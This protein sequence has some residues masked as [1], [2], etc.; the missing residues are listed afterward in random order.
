MLFVKTLIAQ[1]GI[2]ATLKILESS[3]LRHDP[4]HFNLL[5]DIASSWRSLQAQVL[6]NTLPYHQIEITSSAL[7]QR[8]LSLLDKI[9]NNYRH[10]TIAIAYSAE[11]EEDAMKI[12]KKLQPVSY[13]IQLAFFPEIS[14]GANAEVPVV[15]AVLSIVHLANQAWVFPAQTIQIA[16][17][18]QL[19][20]LLLLTNGNTPD[21]LP[22][23]W[24]GLEKQ[25]LNSI[26][27]EEKIAIWIGEKLMRAKA[28][29]SPAVQTHVLHAFPKGPMVSF[30]MVSRNLKDAY[31]AY[32]QPAQA[33]AVLSEAIAFRKQADPEESQ[34]TCIRHAD[35]PAP[36]AVPPSVYWQAAFTEAC[37]HGPRMLAAMLL[38]VPD[39][40]FASSVR[41]ERQH[42]LEKLKTWRGE[43]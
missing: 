12:L 5:I 42:L 10:Q 26:G 14:S 4:L 9:E 36:A 17:E 7:R 2:E 33:H 29:S 25:N 3:L 39:L 11:N 34:A 20:L 6:Q 30:H 38:V 32:I 19:P 21:P 22:E 28:I 41:L 16:I 40:A 18:K 24:L 37:L 8:L 35:L 23:K 31:A 43:E 13:P 27:A 15:E 1:D